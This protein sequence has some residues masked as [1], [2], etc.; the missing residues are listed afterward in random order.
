MLLRIATL[1]NQTGKPR[2]EATFKTYLL[3][4]GLVIVLPLTFL[5]GLLL[6]HSARVESDRVEARLIQLAED[7]SSD[8]DRDIERHITVL[9][10][11]ATSPSMEEQDFEAFHDRASRALSGQG[12]IVLADRDLNQIVNTF[13]PFGQQPAKTGDPETVKRVLATGQP[14]VSDLFQ[15]LVTKGPAFNI[16]IPV[17]LNNEIRY[18][19][20]YARPLEHLKSIL[21]QQSAGPE[22]IRVFSRT[23]P[24][25]GRRR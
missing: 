22:W 17:R 21:T 9:N 12:F 15:G 18:V 7:L 11:L 4:F 16:D 14:Q 13:V 19:L 2:T 20:A 24:C 6:I 8:I 23:T 3:V 5:T 25:P 1:M 10:T